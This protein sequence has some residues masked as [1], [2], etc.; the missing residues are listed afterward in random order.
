MFLKKLLI[1]LIFY[2]FLGSV[3]AQTSDKKAR[4]L[5]AQGTQMIDTYRQYKEGI[6]KINQALE[7]DPNY[8][9][10]HLKLGQVYKSLNMRNMYV[11]EIKFHYGQVAKMKP[12]HGMY[13]S[14]YHDLA[15]IYLGE[16]SYR[17]AEDYLNRVLKQ[18]RLNQRL[19]A[20]AESLKLNVDFALQGIQNPLDFSPKEMSKQTINRYAFN[21]HPVLTAD[22]SEMVIS[23]RN[24]V[25]NIDENVMIVTQENGKWL[26]AESISAT[27]NTPRNEGMASISG[28]GKTLVFTSCDRQDTYGGCDLYVSQ[29][30]G[31]EWSKPLNLG[32]K[33]NSHAKDSE[34]SLSADGRTVYFS[35]NRK[36]GQGRSDLYK[37]VKQEDG[38]W[39]SAM[40]LGEA[41]NTPGDEVTPFVHA[42]G[43]TLYFAS[44]GHIG[45][46]G[47]D[48]YHSSTVSGDTT[49]PINIGYPINTHS[50]EGSLYI[51]P[52]YTKGYY[53]KYAKQGQESYSLIYEFDFPVEARP[54]QVSQYMKGKVY[55][56]LTKQAL[57]ATVKLTD[58]QKDMQSSFVH[59]DS[60]NGEYMLVLT[61]GK[62]YALYA[63]KK[64]YLYHSI[65]LDY[66]DAKQFDAV[67]LDIYLM[68]IQPSQITVL[69][70]L[71]YETD[72]SDLTTKSKT[73]LDKLVAFMNDNP[74]V[75]IEIGGHTDNVGSM[76]YNLKLSSNRALAVKQY[77]IQNQIGAQRLES[78][79]YA[80]T[81]PLASN[82]TEEGKKQNRR[83]EIKVL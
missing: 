36:G 80:S 19:K 30:S 41:I 71:F 18:P 3:A 6:V 62:E 21:S 65:N 59:S 51:S 45:Y 77:L 56:A 13:V 10:A 27:I 15:K 28:D 25:G 53:E 57:N 54:N 22:Q 64:G 83:I 11:E 72:K 31:Q 68:P 32:K 39:S 70:N 49:A 60:I 17:L 46:G 79:G 55:D 61:E 42:D 24:R 23:V 48:I 81:K 67:Q 37:T 7:R 75:R 38:E 82:Q 26:P 35:S 1:A 9:E 47:Y 16:G 20:N 2:T 34:P 14:V 40:N 78:K 69:S 12:D 73:E 8:L 5:L 4:K 74:S 43:E 44:N 58:I 63:E 50:N 66:S 52:N 76:A 33:V 29:R